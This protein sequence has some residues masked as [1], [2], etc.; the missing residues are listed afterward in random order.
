MYYFRSLRI[1]SANVA[2]STLKN[3]LVSKDTNLEKHNQ[4]WFDNQCRE[5]RASYRSALNL[6]NKYKPSRLV[7]SYLKNAEN[8]SATV[9]KGNPSII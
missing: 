5:K 1:F 7:G 8:I 2:K 9:E 6:F 4:L 3:I